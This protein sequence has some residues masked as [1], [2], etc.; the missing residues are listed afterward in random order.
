MYLLVLE[1]SCFIFL[2]IVNKKKSRKGKKEEARRRI[3]RGLWDFWVRGF[4]TANLNNGW[5]VSWV[6]K[7]GNCLY[8]VLDTLMLQY[9]FCIFALYIIARLDL[10]VS[11]ANCRGVKKK[12]YFRFLGKPNRFEPVG[13]V[14]RVTGS[15]PVHGTCTFFGTGFGRVFG[16]VSIYRTS[17]T[18]LFNN[19]KK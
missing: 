6:V 11:L 12:R 5:H 17:C 13:S 10:W 14:Q 16:L 8:F 15:V 18:D 4:R 3:W 2:L 1:T 19:I 9:N 7:D